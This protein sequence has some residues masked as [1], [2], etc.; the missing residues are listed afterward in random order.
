MKEYQKE[1]ASVKGSIEVLDT[2]M[3]MALASEGL[4]ALSST[5]WA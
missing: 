3:L 2:E 1:Q 5:G 4:L